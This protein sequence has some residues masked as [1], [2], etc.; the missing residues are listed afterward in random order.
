M[1]AERARLPR[2]AIL[3]AGFAAGALARMLSSRNQQ[4]S[5]LKRSVAALEAR[6]ARQQAELEER[7]Q[8]AETRL[9]EHDARLKEVPSTGQIVSAMEDLLGKS[10]HGLNQRLAAQAEAVDLLKTTV[11]QTDALLERVL[12]SL[13]SLRQEPSGAAA[14]HDRQT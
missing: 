8:R 9:D 2:A 5:A 10:M 6:C 11:S 13:D 4:V 3:V 1:Q 14:E 12:E 7:V